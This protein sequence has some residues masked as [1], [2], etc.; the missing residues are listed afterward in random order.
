MVWSSIY[1]ICISP[2]W[3]TGH[4]WH[5]F[6]MRTLVW[7]QEFGKCTLLLW[8]LALVVVC[9]QVGVHL[10][11][12]SISFGLLVIA[13]FRKIT[14]AFILSDIF[15]SFVRCCILLN[16]RLEQRTFLLILFI[17]E[18]LWNSFIAIRALVASDVL[19]TFWQ[20]VH[21]IV[22]AF[23]L[24]KFLWN[25][26]QRTLVKLV[27]CYAKASLRQ[28]TSFQTFDLPND[29][30]AVWLLLMTGSLSFHTRSFV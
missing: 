4:C 3:N 29:G 6:D 15:F 8:R 19:R 23:L 7:P 21:A 30:P 9:E 22:V 14:E 28:W 11:I 24:G 27:C 12:F 26:L 10:Q 2:L 13:N 18:V 1:L 16:Y 20:P 5:F 17:F 25:V